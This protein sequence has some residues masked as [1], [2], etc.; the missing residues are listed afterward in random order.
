MSSAITVWKESAIRGA[1]KDVFGRLCAF[2]TAASTASPTATEGYL[3]RQADVASATAK[4]FVGTEQIGTTQTLTVSSL[5]YNTLQTSGI[6][7][8]LTGGGGNAYYQ[9][10][11]SLLDVKSEVPVRV[12]IVLTMTDGTK[13]VWLWDITVTDTSV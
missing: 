2:T 9:I 3:I 10:P 13:T 7:A 1:P 11:A 4:A 12:E 6:W 8:R 5:I